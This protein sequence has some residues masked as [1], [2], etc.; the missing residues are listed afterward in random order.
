MKSFLNL[1][2]CCLPLLLGAQNNIT[3]T[4]KG[5]I[6]QD[7]GGYRTNYDME[8]VL[9]QEGDKITGRSTVRVDDIF[10][11]MDLEGEMVSGGY[12]RF[13]E[14]AIVDFKKV[15]G[16]EWCIKRGQLLLKFE[17]DEVKLEGF[18]QGTTSFSTCIPGKIFVKKMSPRA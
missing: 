15:E 14:K 5:I 13:Q 18:W 7:E 10:A 12:F 11:V 3:G 8:L 9:K 6:T 4:W 16:L 1:L 17:K 2:F